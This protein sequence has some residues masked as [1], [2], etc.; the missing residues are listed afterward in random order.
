MNPEFI[1]DQLFKPFQSTKPTG[2]GVGAFES[3]QYVTEL[4]GQ[5][6]VESTV[7]K[8]SRFTIDLPASDGATSALASKV[9]A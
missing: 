6:T 3:N 5:I 2:M 4:G 7:G 1:R 9:V 8:G